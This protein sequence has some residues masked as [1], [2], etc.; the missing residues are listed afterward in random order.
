MYILKRFF[1]IVL[2]SCSSLAIICMIFIFVEPLFYNKNSKGSEEKRFDVSLKLYRSVEKYVEFY[3]N[4]DIESLKKSN[5]IYNVKDEDTYKKICSKVS[6]NYKFVEIKRIEKCFNNVFIIEY[7]FNT[8]FFENILDE[9]E[10]NK[11]IIKL[12]GNKIK[13]FYDSLLEQ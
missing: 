5:L 2:V 7:S 11:L 1:N 3:V 9:P 12:R 13:I 6:S 8:D 10:V 4:N